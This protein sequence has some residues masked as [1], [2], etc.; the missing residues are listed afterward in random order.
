[1]HSQYLEV[2]SQRDA[3]LGDAGP[4]EETAQEAEVL[5]LLA[6][7]RRISSQFAVLAVFGAERSAYITKKE[8]PFRTVYAQIYSVSSNTQVERL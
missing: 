3:R 4:R 6:D 7:I 5:H 2:S 1:M 8:L